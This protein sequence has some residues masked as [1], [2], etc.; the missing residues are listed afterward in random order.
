M[1]AYSLD[2][3][4]VDAWLQFNQLELRPPLPA[5]LGQY[6]RALTRAPDVARLLESFQKWLVE[7]F[8]H[9]QSGGKRGE[10]SWLEVRLR[11][12]VEGVLHGERCE[13]GGDRDS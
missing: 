5:L 2:R 9:A 10:P 13:S 6:L 7:E 8:G 11:R 12:A 4:L 1:L 3:P